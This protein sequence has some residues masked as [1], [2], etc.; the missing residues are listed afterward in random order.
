MIDSSSD[1]I[2]LMNNK[3]PKEGNTNSLFYKNYN[4]EN[5]DGKEIKQVVRS[6]NNTNTN[7]NANQ[8]SNLISNINTNVIANTNPTDNANANVITTT[9]TFA[10]SNV[11]SSANLNNIHSTRSK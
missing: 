5:S 11:N 4:S 9:N 7:S 1:A 10:I 8:N 6:S 2:P 3:I